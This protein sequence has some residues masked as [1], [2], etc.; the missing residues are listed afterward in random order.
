MSVLPNEMQILK[1][2][3]PSTLLKNNT[4]VQERLTSDFVLELVANLSLASLL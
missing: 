3:K 2:P 1:H 4:Q